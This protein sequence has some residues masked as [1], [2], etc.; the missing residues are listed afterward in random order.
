[1]STGPF[2]AG[3]IVRHPRRPEWGPGTIQRIETLT[4][5]GRHDQRLWI[6]FPNAGL[7]T[8]LAS[9][10]ELEAVQSTPLNDETLVAREMSGETGWLAE[11]S[12]RKPEDAMTAIPSQA[13]DPF[14]SARR[15]LEFT[16]GLYR[17]DAG[18]KL[19]DWAIAQS[20]LGD[21]LSRFCR[22]ELEELFRRW[23]F[24][25]DAHLGRLLQDSELR[26]APQLVQELLAKAP[27]SAQQAA[28]RAMA[29]R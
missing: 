14:S 9:V 26:A 21:P 2:S 4:S 3:D 11:I 29:M 27:V 16:L 10:A 15:R 8:L 22:P 25:R 7:K 23:A 5:G 13:S 17:F 19:V 20:G 1:M 18:A 12:K 24:D 28:K 6:R